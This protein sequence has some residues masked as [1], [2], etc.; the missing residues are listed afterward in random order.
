M[1]KT[2]TYNLR[3]HAMFTTWH[4]LAGAVLGSTVHKVIQLA[5]RPVLVIG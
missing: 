3:R 4:D 2:G 5:D 1:L